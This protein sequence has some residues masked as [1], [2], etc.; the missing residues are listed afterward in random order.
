MGSI[1]VPVAL[2][3]SRI[4]SRNGFENGSGALARAATRCA[5]GNSFGTRPTRLPATA[6]DTPATPVIAP[7]GGARSVPQIGCERVT[8]SVD[9]T[10]SAADPKFGLDVSR[11]TFTVASPS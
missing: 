7:P 8:V 2:P 10:T 1:V 3:A 4:F 5:N 9:L 6:P 11:L